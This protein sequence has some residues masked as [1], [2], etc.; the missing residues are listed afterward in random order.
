ME[1]FGWL[2][3]AAI[4]ILSPLSWIKPSPAQQKLA[5]LREEARKL[6]IKVTLTPLKFKDGSRLEGSAYRWLRPPEAPV[7][8]GYLC[9]LRRDS[10]IAQPPGAPW[11]ENWKV[12]QG[13]MDFLTTEQQEILDQWLEQ[14]PVNVF[15]VEW[16]SATLALWWNERGGDAELLASWDQK[17]RELLALPCKKPSE[18]VWR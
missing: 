10:E 14:L 4:L 7:M 13:Q 3:L 18:T 12:V 6:G 16:G 17:A 5:T 8:L 11:G 15:A 2:L 1:V 9:L